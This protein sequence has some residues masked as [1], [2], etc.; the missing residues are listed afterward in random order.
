[1]VYC[2]LSYFARNNNTIMKSKLLFLTLF[3]IYAF[4]SKA[5][6]PTYIDT[7]GLVAWYPFKGNANDLSGKGNNGTVFGGATFKSDRFG[8]AN[9]AIYLDGSNDYISIPRNSS[10]E[11]TTGLT[12]NAWITPERMANIGWRTLICKPYSPGIDPYI[13]FSIQTSSNSPVNNRWQFN[14]SKGTQGSIKSLLASKAYPDKDTL[15]L[16]AVFGNGEMK[17]YL[18]GV[19]DTAIAFTGPIGYA[20]Q[21]LLIGYSLGGANEYYK[22]GI[23]ELGIWNKALSA[24]QLERLYTNG[25]CKPNFEIS[26]SKP[27]YELNDLATISSEQMPNRTY[28]W[29]A[30]PLQMGWM[31]IPN[32]STFS[33]TK[34]SGLVIN[35]IRVN[36]YNLPIRLIAVSDL[37][38]D[39]SKVK[40]LNVRYCTPDTFYVKGNANSDTLFISI[41]SSL[42][43][44]EKLVNKI[45]VYPNPAS[46]SLNFKLDKPGEYRAELTGISGSILVSSL[47]SSMDISSLAAGVYVLSIYDSRN[48]LIST[49][50]I[51]IVR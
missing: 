27:I 11:P 35:P 39:T 13:S 32:N 16:T 38:R 26:S 18:N 49:N 51:A 15:M 28:Q 30:N 31:N 40:E 23:D 5:Q 41:L 19:L 42:V 10:V 48:R 24:V 29:Q 47:E 21:N 34:T 17:L 14:L 46:T 12:I 8:V 50:K 3:V 43:P 7:N 36:H 20:N 2:Y 4:S 9:E 45:K 22:G 33:G 6:L 25:G 37:C 1:M 44:E